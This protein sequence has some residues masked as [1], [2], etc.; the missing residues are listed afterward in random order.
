MQLS[1]LVETENPAVSGYNT[2]QSRVLFLMSEPL[3]VLTKTSLQSEQLQS[4]EAVNISQNALLRILW[5][6]L[7]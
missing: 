6:L 4:D 1:S 2:L 3:S 7:T 5:T